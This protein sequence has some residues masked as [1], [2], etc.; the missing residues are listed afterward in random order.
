MSFKK[1]VATTFGL[2][3]FTFLAGF[4]N[5]I[6]AARLLGPEGRG[7]F[8][9]YSTAVELMAMMLG[10]GLP[11]ALLYFAAKDQ[12]DRPGLFNFSLSALGASTLAFVALMIISN[13]WGFQHLLLP[14]PYNKLTDQVMMVVYFLGLSGWYLF[15][16]IL[17]GHRLFP[18]TNLISLVSIGGTLVIYALLFFYSSERASP[19]VFFFV[20]MLMALVTLFGCF[21]VHHRYVSSSYRWGMPPRDGVVSMVRYSMVIF[22]SNIMFFLTMKLDYWFVNHFAGAA[23]LGLYSLASNVGLT[24]MLLPNSVGLVLT[25]FTANEGVGRVDRWSAFLCRLTFFISCLI[26]LVLW[27]T[28]DQLIRFLYGSAFDDSF[29][30]LKILLIGIVPYAVFTVLRNY[31]AGAG[32]LKDLLIVST[33]GLLITVVLDII[34]IPAKGAMGAAIASVSTY[35][36]STAL[37]VWRFHRHTSTRWHQLFVLNLED[38]KLIRAKVTELLQL[39]N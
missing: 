8:T 24:M 15:V 26:A 17:N 31:F 14:A 12:F 6:M 39:K 30:L 3:A 16:S 38:I 27:L 5:S 1:S 36:V 22:A 34:L 19:S 35:V 23:D 29:L 7:V 21:W 9:I 28:G 25:A 4:L 37:L 11:H 10:L 20:Q 18:Q 13:G 33:L 32:L 2:N